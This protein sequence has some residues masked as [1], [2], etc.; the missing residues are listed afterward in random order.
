MK[1]VKFTCALLMTARGS[2]VRAALIVDTNAW[3]NLLGSKNVLVDCSLYN[4]NFLYGTYII[5]FTKC[6]ESIVFMTN[7]FQR[8]R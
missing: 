4:V 5:L 8:Q 6:D 1:L 3:S 7:N 2:A